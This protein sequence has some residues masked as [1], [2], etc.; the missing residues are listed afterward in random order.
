M[1]LDAD[2]TVPPEE[3]PRFYDAIAK[4]KAD[5]VNGTRMVYPPEEQ[6][7]N[8]LHIIGNKMFSAIFSYILAHKIS[9]TLCGT[10]ALRSRDYWRIGFTGDGWGDFDILFGSTR[11]KL[12]YVEVP[13]HYKRRQNGKSKMKTFSHGLLL[14]KMCFLGFVELKLKNAPLRQ[15]KKKSLPRNEDDQTIIK[16]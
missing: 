11:S 7:M 14:M 3:L 2:M 6:S 5:F 4:G 8:F 1:I 16:N 10:K 9:D 12:R 15:D 13:V